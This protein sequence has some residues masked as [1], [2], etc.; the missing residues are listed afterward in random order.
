MKTHTRNRQPQT[1][2]ARAPM[3]VDK[4]FFAAC[5]TAGIEPSNRQW[6]KWLKGKG[7]AF[8]AALENAKQG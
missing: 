2:A 3:D 7:I 1:A 6:K 4:R 8:A 5:K